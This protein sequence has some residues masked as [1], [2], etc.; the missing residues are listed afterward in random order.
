MNSTSQ[1]VQLGTLLESIGALVKFAGISAA[2]VD[3]DA[4]VVISET[5]ILATDVCLAVVTAAA[6]AVYVTKVVP[7]ADTLTVTLSGNGGAGTQVAWV[8]LTPSA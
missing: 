8:V 4:S 7:T 6:N 3:A 5:G 1:K 2:E